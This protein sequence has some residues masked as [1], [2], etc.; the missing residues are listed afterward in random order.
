MADP[1]VLVVGETPSLGHSIVDL[2]ESGGVRAQ[3]VD[4]VR[5]QEPLSSLAKRY[6]VVVAACNEHHCATARQW[7][8]GAIPDVALVV[9]GG[10]DPLLGRNANLH[11]VPLPLRPSRF[12]GMI[13]GLLDSRVRPSPLSARPS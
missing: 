3:Y 9:V 1:E 6:P 4:D 12:L 2:L 13:H 10:R 8:G 11:L 7:V 5:S